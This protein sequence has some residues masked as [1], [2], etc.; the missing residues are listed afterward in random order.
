MRLPKLTKINDELFEIVRSIKCDKFKNEITS[1]EATN[2]KNWIG[3]EAIYRSPASNEYIFVNKIVELT[4]EI[5][6][7]EI[8]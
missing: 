3:C 7:L 1:E 6:E 4:E 5:K 2:L 8:K